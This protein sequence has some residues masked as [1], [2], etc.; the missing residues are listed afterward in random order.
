M[1]KSA[2]GYHWLLEKIPELL[3][4]QI[5][6]P[7][8]AERLTQYCHERLSTNRRFEGM[9]KT[10][11]FSVAIFGVLLLCSGVFLFFNYN[12]DIFPLP[13]RLTVSFLPVVIGMILGIFALWKRN[14]FLWREISAGIS[15]CGI[16]LC[17]TLILQIY[18]Q[19]VASQEFFFRLF[20][21]AFGL[22]LVFDS[23][24]LELLYCFGLYHFLLDGW[25]H[26]EIQFAILTIL[27]LSRLLFHLRSR[28]EPQ[29]V[30][31]YY[32]LLLLLPVLLSTFDL[33]TIWVKSSLPTFLLLMFAMGWIRQNL[34]GNQFLLNPLLFAG[35]VALNFT[36]AVAN[37]AVSLDAKFLD[38][39]FV[40]LFS[41]PAVSSLTWLTITAILGI[42]PVLHLFRATPFDW[43]LAII[44]AGIPLLLWGMSYP[45]VLNA[46]QI[47]LG[48]ALT[49][50][51]ITRKNIN[52]FSLGIL[53]LFFLALVKF[54]SADVNVLLRAAGFGICGL[55]VLIADFWF[56][57]YCRQ[58]KPE[59]REGI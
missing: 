56:F 12:W 24:F 51:G 40:S 39:S 10:A 2:R 44:L 34:T 9:Q 15:G 46:Y 26:S 41:L 31:G 50:N 4:G 14:T 48:A 1:M 43:V 27:I 53:T 22:I 42:W 55:A 6:T 38:Y 30:F 28:K 11:L 7:E 45:Y 57:R 35:F 59:P 49:I 58:T 47:L 3:S 25:K 20:L 54:F 29:I 32:L 19:D 36:A 21:I 5:V 37:V 52:I 16:A 23:Y 33:T 17:W 13:V 18:Q 8:E